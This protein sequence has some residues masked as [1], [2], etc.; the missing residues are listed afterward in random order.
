MDSIPRKSPPPLP[1]PAR[2]LGEQRG[3][4]PPQLHPSDVARVL[5]KKGLLIIVWRGDGQLPLTTFLPFNKGELFRLIDHKEA[6]EAVYLHPTIPIRRYAPNSRSKGGEWVKLSWDTFLAVP[7]KR[8]LLLRWKSVDED[9]TKLRK[10]E[11]YI[12]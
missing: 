9:V 2:L 12:A 7:P 6:L 5:D 11:E 10:W 8:R 3:M 1:R 4:H